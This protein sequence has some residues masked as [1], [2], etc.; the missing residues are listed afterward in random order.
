LTGRNQSGAKFSIDGV[1]LSDGRAIEVPYGD[2]LNKV[3]E[4]GRGTVMIMMTL[5]LVL[6]SQCDDNISDTVYLSAHF[7]P[8]SSDINISSPTDKWTLNTNSPLDSISGK[9][10]MPD[11]N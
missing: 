4:V 9:Y 11:Y 8:S 7:I 1:P 2:I 5:A 6:K 10:Y 3:L